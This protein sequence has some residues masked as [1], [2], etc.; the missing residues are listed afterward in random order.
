MTEEQKRQAEEKKLNIKR[1]QDASEYVDR[2]ISHYWLDYFREIQSIG[3]KH[4]VVEFIRCT[5][6]ELPFM[7]RAVEKLNDPILNELPVVTHGE[8]LLDLIFDDF[9][10]LHPTKYVIDVPVQGEFGASPSQILAQ[11]QKDLKADQSWVDFLSNDTAPV[12]R[13]DFSELIVH[14]DQLFDDGGLITLIFADPNKKWIIF[15]SIEEEW[16]WGAWR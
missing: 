10:S 3:M 1:G 6:V 13:L 2:F 7:Q 15:R 12:L 14:A 16:R 4:S 9:P 8:P 5:E 11:A